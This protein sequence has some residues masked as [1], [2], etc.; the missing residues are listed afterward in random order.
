M[1]V[2]RNTVYVTGI[3]KPTSNDPITSTYESFFV[4]LIID[5]ETDRIEDMT[6]NTVK[7]MTCQFIKSIMVGYNIVEDMDGLI[8]EINGRFLGLAQK[9]VVAALKDA[10]N[11]YLM[12]AK[13]GKI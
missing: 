8:E 7:E 9:A 6:C 2:D 13:S 11:K 3:S 12:S 1:T 4:G 10:R 5:R